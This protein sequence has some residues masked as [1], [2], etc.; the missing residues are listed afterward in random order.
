MEIVEQLRFAG[1]VHWL[2]Q[3]TSRDVIN[4]ME[5][6]SESSPFE[7]RLPE[8]QLQPILHHLPLCVHYGTRETYRI[9][10]ITSISGP[11][12][13]LAGSVFILGSSHSL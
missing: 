11:V 13:R 2:A 6:D 10:D 5:I 7:R 12:S 8:Q 1:P 3:Q 4:L 9:M